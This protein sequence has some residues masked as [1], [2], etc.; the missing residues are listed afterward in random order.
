M[1]QTSAKLNQT[2]RSIREDDVELTDVELEGVPLSEKTVRKLGD[3]LRTNRLVLYTKRAISIK[4][5]TLCC[6]KLCMQYCH[7][8]NVAIIDKASLNCIIM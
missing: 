3:A 8:F 7:S 1:G 4:R 6:I 5:E 2:V